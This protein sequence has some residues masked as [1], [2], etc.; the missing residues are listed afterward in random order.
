MQSTKNGKD[1]ARS[2]GMANTADTKAET[3]INK[4]ATAEEIM[5]ITT[6][7]TMKSKTGRVAGDTGTAGSFTTKAGN[8]Y[9][10]TGM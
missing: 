7:G 6:M 5:L 4:S 3:E 1:L 2:T 8:D 9:A 10:E